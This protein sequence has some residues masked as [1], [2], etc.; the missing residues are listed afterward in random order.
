MS[1]QVRELL[2]EHGEHNVRSA[3][4][5]NVPEC[6]KCGREINIAADEVANV[7]LER[8][9]TTGDMVAHYV[10]PEC[11]SSKV[12]DGDVSR[13]AMW[14]MSTDLNFVG[15]LRG[16]RP[17]LAMLVESRRPFTA[18]AGGPDGLT[19]ALTSRGL[20]TVR[21]PLAAVTAPRLDAAWAC[22]IDDGSLVI[23]DGPGEILRYDDLSPEFVRALEQDGG[24]LLLAAANFGLEAPDPARI[25]IVLAAGDAVGGIVKYGA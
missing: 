21:E 22:W 18:I 20:L 1:V 12:V 2:G 24:L 4:M 10:H 13:S 23:V 7:V 6:W 16:A 8:N 3:A 14:G 11:S 25:D 15:V 9:P 19:Q 17:R 5:A